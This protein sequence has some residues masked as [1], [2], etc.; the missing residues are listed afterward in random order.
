MPCLTKEIA[1]SSAQPHKESTLTV[2][3]GGGK[4]KIIQGFPASSM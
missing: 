1:D 2:R 4:R 3:V